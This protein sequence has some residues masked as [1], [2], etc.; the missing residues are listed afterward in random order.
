MSEIVAIE[1]F[2][3]IGGLHYGLMKASPNAKVVAAFDTNTH[4]NS[5][6]LH[7]FNLKPSAKGIER[8]TAEYL[9]KFKANFWLLSPPCQPYTQGGKRMDE[10]DPRAAGL[11]NLINVLYEVKNLPEF[12]FL[13]N[14]PNFEISNSRNILVKALNLLSY[15]FDEFL[16]SPLLVG[17]PNDRKRYYLAVIYY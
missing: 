13:E 6:Y 11:L 15:D 1:F 7:N 12:I 5:V 4:A 14:V 3:G 17:I 2:S 10:K 9:D 16:I 8:L